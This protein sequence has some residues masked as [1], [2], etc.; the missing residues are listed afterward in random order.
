M[1]CRFRRLM[2]EVQAGAIRRNHF[3]PWEIEILVDFQNCHLSRRRWARALE[4]YRKAVE[5]QLERGCGPPLK[6]SQF[7]ALRNAPKLG[8][9]IG[10]PGSAV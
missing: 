5:R 3:E 6:P 7:L 8:R 2:A 9:R 4:R 1:L 10:E